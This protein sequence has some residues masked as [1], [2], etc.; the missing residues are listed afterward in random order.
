MTMLYPIVLETEESGAVSAYVPG[1]PVYAAAYT[2]EGGARYSRCAD[3]VSERAPRKSARCTCARRTLLRQRAAKGRHLW[4]SGV[5]G[6]QSKHDEGTRLAS[7]WS[8]WWPTSEDRGRTITYKGVPLAS[9]TDERKPLPSMCTP[10]LQT[11]PTHQ[12]LPRGNAARRIGDDKT[13]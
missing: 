10:D 1:L 12:I 7:Q 4:R 2:W 9:W 3:R 6:R 11:Q 13:P 5:G 8:A